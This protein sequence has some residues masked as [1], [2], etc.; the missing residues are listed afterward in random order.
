MR[1][2][3]LHPS[4]YRQVAEWEYPEL[5]EN[6]DW[7]RYEKEMSRPHWIH[8]GIYD[9]SS[10]IG[11]VSLEK[12]SHEKSE[13]HMAEFHVVTARRKIKPAQLATLLLDTADYLFQQDFIALTARIPVE[14][15]AAVRLAL[16]C[17]MSEYGHTP[18]LRL[19]MLTKQRYQK[20]G[21]V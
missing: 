2:E 10:F 4:Q 20:Y 19:F 11:C 21:R 6:A 7:E 9:D 8:F 3:L 1:M 17:G 18:T 15:R 16:R 5:P 14:K 12:I 13:Y